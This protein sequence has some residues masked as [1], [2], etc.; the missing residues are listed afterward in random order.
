MDARRRL[1]LVVPPQPARLRKVDDA[2]VVVEELVTVW[3][4]EM[5]RA[6]ASLVSSGMGSSL[7][8]AWSIAAD[9]DDYFAR[10]V[11]EEGSTNRGPIMIENLQ[12]PK[13]GGPMTSRVNAKTKQRFWGCN[14]FPPCRG[15][16][17][18]DGEAPHPHQHHDAHRG[19][20]DD[21]GEL[22]LPSERACRNDEHRW[23]A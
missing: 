19:L 21:A 9:A 11:C 18:T 3:N 14:L 22:E 16:R 12:C 17:N 7:A 13:C 4:G 10:R 20:H 6:G 5:G 15:T 8:R 1:E 2:P 23:R